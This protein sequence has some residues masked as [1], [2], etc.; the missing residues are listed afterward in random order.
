MFVNWQYVRGRAEMDSRAAEDEAEGVRGRAEHAAGRAGRHAGM[1][2]GDGSQDLH[3]VRGS[4]Q[5]RQGRHD[6]GDHRTREPTRVPRGRV[7]LS[8]RAREV[9]DVRAALHA[10]PAGGAPARS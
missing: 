8:D 2:Q 1:G 5:R 10:A 4:R 9:A 6:Q 7:A 3:R